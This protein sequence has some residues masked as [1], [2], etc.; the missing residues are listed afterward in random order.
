MPKKRKPEKCKVCGTLMLRVRYRLN[1]PERAKQW[2]G[3]SA[4]PGVYYVFVGSFCQD[5]CQRHYGVAIRDHDNAVI[6]E[7]QGVQIPWYST[8]PI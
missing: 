2:L 3:S 1:T 4:A 5:G 7:Y 6:R 8:D